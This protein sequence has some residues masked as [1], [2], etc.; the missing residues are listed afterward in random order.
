MTVADLRKGQA[1]VMTAD[2]TSFRMRPI[3][4]GFT[5]ADNWAVRG[6]TGG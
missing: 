6:R 4:L 3:R 2:T 5:G 1:A